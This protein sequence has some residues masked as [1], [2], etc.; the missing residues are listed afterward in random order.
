[1]ASAVGGEKHAG[2]DFADRGRL[3]VDRNPDTLRGQRIG[4]ES[5]PDP[6]TNDRDMGTGNHD[7]LLVT[8]CANKIGYGIV[9]SHRP[10]HFAIACGQTRRDIGGRHLMR[11]ACTWPL[12]V[13]GRSVIVLTLVFAL[14]ALVTGSARAAGYPNRP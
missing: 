7:Q 6:A 11:S 2:P 14:S 4:G 8:E 10:R 13:A 3:L 9:S 1:M 5:P 12:V